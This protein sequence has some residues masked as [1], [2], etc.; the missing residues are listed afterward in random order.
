MKIAVKHRIPLVRHIHRSLATPAPNCS[1][2]RG[3]P[4]SPPASIPQLEHELHALM[5]TGNISGQCPAW[6]IEVADE[7]A[8]A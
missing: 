2:D 4:E 1:V 6:Q 3:V 7:E 5:G 8:T